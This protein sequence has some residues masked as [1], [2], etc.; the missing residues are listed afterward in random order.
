LYWLDNGAVPSDTVNRIL[1]FKGVKFL[2]HLMRGVKLGLFDHETAMAKF[3]KWNE[4]HESEVGT[5]REAH[6][7]AKHDVRVAAMAPIVKK[8]EEVAAPVVEETTEAPVAE[9]VTE[10][11]VAEV[12]AEA[13]V[14]EVVAETPAADTTEEATP[15]AE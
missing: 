11:P 2:K 9:E 4:T 1:S 5:R 10:A 15:T 13:P 6:K 14:A 3:D 7:K 8:V 12:A